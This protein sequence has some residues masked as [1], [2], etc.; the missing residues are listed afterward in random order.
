MKNIE[1]RIATENHELRRSRPDSLGRQGFEIS[2]CSGRPPI[3][4]GDVERVK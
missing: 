3:L 2:R 1:L 4:T